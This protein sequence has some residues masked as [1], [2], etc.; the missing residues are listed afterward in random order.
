MGTSH[1]FDILTGLSMVTQLGVQVV[2][3]PVVFTL[4]GV[5]LQNRFSLGVWLPVAALAVGLVTGGC[6]FWRFCRIWLFKHAKPDEPPTTTTRNE[7]PANE[8]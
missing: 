3:P 5:W 1:R 8:D 2:L 6:S 4:L 7:D